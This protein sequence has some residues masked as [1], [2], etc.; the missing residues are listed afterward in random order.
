MKIT[1]PLLA[2]TELAQHGWKWPRA[3]ADAIRSIR[4]KSRTQQSFE[5]REL[6]SVSH[7]DLGTDWPPYES[8]LWLMIYMGTDMS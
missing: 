3:M 6:Q 7:F 8:F 5:T 1:K 2:R 4:S